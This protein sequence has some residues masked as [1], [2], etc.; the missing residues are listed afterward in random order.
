MKRLVVT[1]IVF[2]Q[3]YL[4]PK[5]GF[6]CAHRQ[7][8][9]GHSCSEAIKQIVLSQGVLG[10]VRDISARF[11]AC[12][13]AAVKLHERV[14][15]PMRADI[16]CGLSGCIGCA[17]VGTFDACFLSGG[18]ASAPTSVSRPIFYVPISFGTLILIL[19]CL[20]WFY[21][22]Q[23]DFIEI[24]LLEGTQ[25]A[26]DKHLAKLFKNQ[27][28]DYQIVL[29]ANGKQVKTNTVKN[30][31]AANWLQLKPSYGVY[32]ADINRLTIVNKQILK[33]Q[34]L[35]EFEDPGSEGAGQYYEYRIQNNWSF[36]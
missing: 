11:K 12:R 9:G 13:N 23:V 24:R 17:D 34:A 28:P 1:L 33:D 27:L 29:D 5:K 26:S 20:Y 35:E 10:G 25:E 36:F 4:S 7:L 6:C 18:A 31:S 22:R 30:S 15:T 21:G 8:H 19:A 16:D 3:S 2:Y 14:G 32:R